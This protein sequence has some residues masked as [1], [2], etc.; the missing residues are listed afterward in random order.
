MLSKCAWCS[1]ITGIKRPLLNFSVT[2]GICSK[3]RTSSL[4]SIGIPVN[5]I[6][7]HLIALKYK[8]SP[9]SRKTARA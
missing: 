4:V 8:K 9:P 3:C 1:R 2:H 7:C 6:Q 5:E